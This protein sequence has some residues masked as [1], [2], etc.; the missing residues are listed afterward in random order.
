M[1]SSSYPRQNARV[2]EPGLGR[3]FNRLGKLRSGTYGTYELQRYRASGLDLVV[4]GDP[5][6][7]HRLISNAPSPSSS[8]ATASGCKASASRGADSDRYAPVR[9]RLRV[10]DVGAIFVQYP[11]PRLGPLP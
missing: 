3:C 2:R 4:T 6:V 8:M 7:A 5:A 10:C 11:N 1:C 9:R